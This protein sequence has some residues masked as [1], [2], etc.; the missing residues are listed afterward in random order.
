MILL[1]GNPGVAAY[2]EEFMIELF[3]HSGKKVPV[4]CV[5]HAGHVNVPRDVTISGK[6]ND[7]I[8]N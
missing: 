7:N 3:K 1:T 2:Y 5:S 6:D 8:C 4:W